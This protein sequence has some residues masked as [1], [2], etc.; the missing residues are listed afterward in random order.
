MSAPDQRK[1]VKAVLMTAIFA[2]L[3]YR[4]WQSPAFSLEWL[5]WTVPMLFFAY[6]QG[7]AWGDYFRR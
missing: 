2:V 4:S 7:T 1:L 5:I 3:L 6:K